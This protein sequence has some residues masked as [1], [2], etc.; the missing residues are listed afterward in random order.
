MDPTSLVNYGALGIIVLWF[1]W[2]MENSLRRL[3]KAVNL[4]SMALIRLL[5]RGNPQG[6]AELAKELSKENGNG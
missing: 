1:M 4:N 5:E 3:T 2:R 6:A